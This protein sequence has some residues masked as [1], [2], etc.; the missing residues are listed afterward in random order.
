MTFSRFLGTTTAV[1]G[2]GIAG[3][4]FAQTPQ[5]PGKG[6]PTGQATA[7]G[8]GTPGASGQYPGSPGKGLPGTSSQTGTVVTPP[9]A[10]AADEAP[11]APTV[12]GTPTIPGLKKT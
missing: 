9:P 12:P 4:A 10:G 6:M 7:P 1:L 5:A 3:S 8:K 2:L 11:P